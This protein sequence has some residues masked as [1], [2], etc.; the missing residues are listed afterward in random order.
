M[1]F[2]GV[3]PEEAIDEMKRRG[4]FMWRHRQLEPQVRAL[5]DLVAARP[6][7]VEERHCPA[8]T[9]RTPAGLTPQG[10]FPPDVCP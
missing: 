1:R 10:A 6:C 9:G 8:A 7:S 3:S 4:R 5:G 2:Q